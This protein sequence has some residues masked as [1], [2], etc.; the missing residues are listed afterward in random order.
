MAITFECEHCRKQVEAPDSAA[1]KRGK[2]PYC[3]ETSYI[4]APLGEDDEIPLAPIDEAEERRRQ[5]EERRLVH[6][7]DPLLEAEGNLGGK[8]GAYTPL[9]HR[10][11]VSAE[12]LHHF[13]VNFC[14]DMSASK[15]NRAPRHA[16]ELREFGNTGLQAVED[17]L[18]GKVIE[19]ALDGIPTGVLH[20]FLKE[21]R[22]RLQV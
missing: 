21:L 12:D 17:F 11:D 13:V 16:E 5:E 3:G 1:G 18:S 6:E 19:P 10:K 8:G 22:E 9:E 4:P 7:E 15:L 2:C 20:G 14:L